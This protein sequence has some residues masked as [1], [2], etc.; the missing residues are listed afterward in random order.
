MYNRSV[1]GNSWN[2]NS[3]V[4]EGLKKKKRRRKGRGGRRGTGRRERR[5]R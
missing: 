2:L 1:L 4:V 3:R 5:G